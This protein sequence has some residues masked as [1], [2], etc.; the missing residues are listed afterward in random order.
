M[1][2]AWNTFVKENYAKVTHLPV[3]ERFGALSKMRDGKAPAK[4]TKGGII[5]AAG[6]GSRKGSKKGASK[7]GAGFFGDLASSVGH[8]LPF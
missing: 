5:T 2:S 1:P 8:L 7:K 3:K 6:F 4:K